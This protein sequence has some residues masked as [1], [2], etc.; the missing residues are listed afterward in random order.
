MF[1]VYQHGYTYVKFEILI[2]DSGLSNADML[3]CSFDPQI[4]PK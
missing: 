4:W 2:R 1:V 3:L